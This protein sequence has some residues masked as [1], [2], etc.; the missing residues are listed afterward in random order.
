MRASESLAFG[1]LSSEEEGLGELPF[2]ADFERAKVLEP[3]AFR[4]LRLGLPPQLQPIQVFGLNLAFAG[5]LEEMVPKSEWKVCPLNLG[6]LFDE[7]HP[8]Q[9]F[10]QPFSFCGVLALSQACYQ[11]KEPSLF[12]FFRFEAALDE[13]N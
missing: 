8:R 2:T 3:G 10:F 11:R 7:G 1:R 6:H 4:G 13:I 5:A 9:L 12:L